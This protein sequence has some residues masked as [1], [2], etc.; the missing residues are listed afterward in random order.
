VAT[1]IPEPGS[2]V[3]GVV[4]A[5]SPRDLLSLDIHEGLGAG[6]YTKH[7]RPV[8]LSPSS[9]AVPAVVYV[10]VDDAPGALC[11]PGYDALVLAG[12][13][14]HGLSPSYQCRLADLLAPAN[15]IPQPA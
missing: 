7:M 6:H 15:A 10:A 4:W 9:V 12:A 1:I 5:V 14:Q 13:R 2:V 8:M 11:R 3:E